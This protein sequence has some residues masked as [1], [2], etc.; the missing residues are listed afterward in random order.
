[1]RI[2]STMMSN[3]YLKQLNGIYEQYSKLMEQADGSNLRHLLGMSR[4][5]IYRVKLAGSY[6]VAVM[7]VGCKLAAGTHRSDKGCSSQGCHKV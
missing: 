1:M 6:R 4:R 5:G 2:S 7:L 3:N